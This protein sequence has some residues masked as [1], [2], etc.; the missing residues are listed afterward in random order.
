[1]RGVRR[2]VWGWWRRLRVRCLDHDGRWIE[3]MRMNE[4]ERRRDLYIWVDLMYIFT[5]AGI[6]ERERSLD[7]YMITLA[8]IT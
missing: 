7:I 1:M 2:G 3:G 4:Y 5:C 8:A 6:Q